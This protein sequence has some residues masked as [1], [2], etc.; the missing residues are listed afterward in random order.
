MNPNQLYKIPHPAQLVWFSMT[1][2]M[3]GIVADS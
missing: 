3:R 2:T 1:K